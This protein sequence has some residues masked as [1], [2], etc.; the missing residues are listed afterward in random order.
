[1]RIFAIDTALNGDTVNM[2]TVI[3]GAG[4]GAD[5]TLCPEF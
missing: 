2:K 1:M 3:R 4:L 5:W